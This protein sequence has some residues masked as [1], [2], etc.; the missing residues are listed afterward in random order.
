MGSPLIDRVM[1]KLIGAI[2]KSV[3][4]D[5]TAME[6]ELARSATDWTSVRPPRLQ[7]KP[8]TG[9]YRTVV[10]GF[11]RAGRFM[12]PR[13]RGARDAGDGG[14]PGDGEAGRRGRLLGGPGPGAAQRL[15][16]TVTGSL[17]SVT[18]KTSLTPETTSRAS[19]S[20]SS[21]VASPRFVRASVCLVEMRAGLTRSPW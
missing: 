18:P 20:R 14:R 16:P 8:L 11:P 7:D 1:L 2:L 5:L 17:T 6:S 10:G 21:V 9:S 15:T 13:G 4:V 19:A 12:R 3:Y